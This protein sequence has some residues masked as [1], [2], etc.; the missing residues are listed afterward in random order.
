MGE[1]SS[2]GDEDVIFSTIQTIHRRLDK[3]DPKEFDLVVADECFTGDVEILTNEGF[4]RFD[5]LEKQKVAQIHDDFKLD[6]VQP[7]IMKVRW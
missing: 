6:Y 4:V 5:E 2:N 1:L 3:F 7:I